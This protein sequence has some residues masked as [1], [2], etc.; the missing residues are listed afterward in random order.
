QNA[1]TVNYTGSFAKLFSAGL[2]YQYAL[3]VFPANGTDTIPSLSLTPGS[4]TVITT[5]VPTVVSGTG[6]YTFTIT[7]TNFGS[8][9]GF[10]IAR[11]AGQLV[12]PFYAE[13]QLQVPTIKD[14]D[15]VQCDASCSCITGVSGCT[16]SP[17]A[18]RGFAF[19][20][21][22]LSNGIGFN[23]GK[24]FYFGRMIVQSTNGS[25]LLNMPVP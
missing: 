1:A 14:T 5:A 15:L 23:S 19:G 20:A 13:I 17:N 12:P 10:K 25:E 16:A 8:A 21:T 22:T 7:D 2:N 11:T 24:T 4:S 9:S 6:T 18:N 3:G